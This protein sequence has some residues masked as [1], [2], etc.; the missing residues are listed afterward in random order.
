MSTHNY[1]YPQ[2][3]TGIGV[4]TPSLFSRLMESLRHYENREQNLSA[5]LMPESLH[6]RITDLEMHKPYFFA[7]LLRARVLDLELFNPNVYEYAWVEVRPVTAAADC[8][9]GCLTSRNGACGNNPNDDCLPAN[10]LSCCEGPASGDCLTYL[11]YQGL[12]NWWEYTTNTSWGSTLANNESDPNRFNTTDLTS[13]YNPLQYPCLKANA[14]AANCNPEGEGGYPNINRVAYTKPAMNLMEA[15]NNNDQAGGVDQTY[16]IGDFM[17]QAIGGGDTIR[18][19]VLGSPGSYPSVPECH[20][21][22]VP[23]DHPPCTQY[24]FPLKSTPIV[25][26]HN[27]RESGGTFRQVFQ[28]ANSYDGTCVEC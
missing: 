28:E 19:K 18:S 7:K 25:L 23:L 17:L 2:M 26:M 21:D 10:I 6:N 8:C 13:D 5:D 9:E 12:W 3:T 15:F 24:E 20:D 1:N 4:I 14:A 22:G 27:I 11:N 16:G